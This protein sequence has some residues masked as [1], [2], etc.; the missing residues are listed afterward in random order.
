MVN[1]PILEESF[2]IFKLIVYICDIFLL[3]DLVYVHAKSCKRIAPPQLR[4][5]LFAEK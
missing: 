3:K 1:V 4:P 5:R 2:C